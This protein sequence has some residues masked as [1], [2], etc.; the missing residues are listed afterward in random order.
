MQV[1]TFCTTSMHGTTT[2]AVMQA[3]PAKF[4][5]K[6]LG[7]VPHVPYTAE[8]LAEIEEFEREAA[9][10]ELAMESWGGPDYQ[11]D[12]YTTPEAAQRVVELHEAMAHARDEI[13]AFGAGGMGFEK[14][15]CSP[16]EQELDALET[17]FGWRDPLVSDFDPEIAHWR[18]PIRELAPGGLRAADGDDFVEQCC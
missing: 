14:R 9:A 8:Q 10:Y 7:F 12:Y 16:M 4:H 3:G 5:T 2:Y 1:S 17:Q 11:I 13:H 18:K 6:H 15:A